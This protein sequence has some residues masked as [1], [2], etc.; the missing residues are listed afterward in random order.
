MVASTLWC[1]RP[2]TV[3]SDPYDLGQLEAA[4]CDRIYTMFVDAPRRGLTLVSGYRDPGRQWDLR[5]ERVGLK[6][7]CNRAV[8]AHPATAIPY[9]SKHQTRE[10]ADIGGIDLNWAVA[11]HRA[12]GLWRA[13]P[14]ELWHYQL[15]SWAPTVRILRYPGKRYTDSSNPSTPDPGPA[16]PPTP[17]PAPKEWDEMASEA[18]IEAAAARGA[19][20]EARKLLPF[21]VKFTKDDKDYGIKKGENWMICGEGRWLIGTGPEAG[22]LIAGLVYTGQCQASDDPKHKANSGSI[23]QPPDPWRRLPIIPKP[24]GSPAFT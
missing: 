8:A 9:A 14:S 13:V 24:P 11:N 18:Q 23:P 3:R 21:P 19:A 15:G 5:V 10:A 7:A 6:N 22:R 2:Q 20:A 16:E 4:L 12:Y 1:P 17:P